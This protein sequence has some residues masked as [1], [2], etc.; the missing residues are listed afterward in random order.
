[1]GLPDGADKNKFYIFDFCV[2]FDFFSMGGNNESKAVL[3]FQMLVLQEAPF[4]D[5]VSVVEIF[6]DKS[7]WRGIKSVIDRINANAAS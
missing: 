7:V 5:K 1:M 2:N 6:S 4:K 3:S